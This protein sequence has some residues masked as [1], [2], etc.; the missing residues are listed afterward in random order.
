LFAWILQESK[1]GAFSL[2]GF[3]RQAK[4]GQNRKLHFCL[5]FASLLNLGKSFAY[6]FAGFLPS[7]KE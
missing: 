3:C 7:R 2:L 4:R 6:S 5:I 1:Y